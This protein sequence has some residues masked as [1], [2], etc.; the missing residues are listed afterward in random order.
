MP[1]TQAKSADIF[2]DIPEAAEIEYPPEVLERWEKQFEVA[3]LKY[4]TGEL[5]P[6]SVR[7]FAAKKGINLDD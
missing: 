3:R 1:L 4:A 6:M 7:E 5:Q 2:S